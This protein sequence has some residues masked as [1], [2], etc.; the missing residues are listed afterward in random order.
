MSKKLDPVIGV[1]GGATR[2]TTLP[3]DSKER[4]AYPIATG[5]L[6]YF[7]DAI[8]AVAH[9]SHKANE[10]HNPGQPLQWDRSKS[11]DEDNTFMRH[12]LQRGTID[13]DGIRHTA[14]VAWRA[15]AMLQKEIERERRLSKRNRV[16]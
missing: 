9:L 4:K 2:A 16:R 12:V 11:K 1:G 13:D 7:P 3:T 10:Q 5:F 14:K 6:D 15:M 8:V